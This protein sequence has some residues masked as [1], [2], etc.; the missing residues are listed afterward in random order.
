FAARPVFEGPT[1]YLEKVHCHFSTLT[2]GAGYEAHIDGHDVAIAVL[3]GTVETLG[4]TVSPHG[5]IFCPAG[6]SHGMRNPGLLPAR[7]VVLEFHRA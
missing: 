6:D 5:A 3:E 7:Y 1:E 4:R 2:P